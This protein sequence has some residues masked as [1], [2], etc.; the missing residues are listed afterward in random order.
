MKLRMLYGWLFQVN[1]VFRVSLEKPH[2]LSRTLPLVLIQ[3]SCSDNL[4]AKQTNF[5]EAAFCYKLASP[6]R[7]L[8][9]CLCRI[10]AA[11]DRI[12]YGS[13]S[14]TTRKPGCTAERASD[15]G[16]A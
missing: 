5:M 1:I 7:K 11:R 10:L 2:P 9:E 15:P 12:H 13:V 4:Y 6:Q 3:S 8:T 16:N 14:L